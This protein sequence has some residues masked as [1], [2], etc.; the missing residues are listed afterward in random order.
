MYKVKKKKL[1][2][3]ENRLSVLRFYLTWVIP[4]FGTLFSC[5][6]PLRSSSSSFFSIVGSTVPPSS[7]SSM[8]TTTAVILIVQVV[9]VVVVVVF[10]YFFSLV[11]KQY[12]DF[13]CV[14]VT[15]NLSAQGAIVSVFKICFE[16]L[17]KMCVSFIF[18]LNI[19]FLFFNLH[20]FYSLL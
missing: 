13:M 12:P 2:N 1:I 3:Q 18:M 15:S 6:F 17:C 8:T 16:C 10:F 4:P 5:I 7:H 11:Y 14:C 20:Y 19:F 9:G